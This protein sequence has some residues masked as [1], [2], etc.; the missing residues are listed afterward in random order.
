MARWRRFAVSDAT[1]TRHDMFKPAS[2]TM[3]AMHDGCDSF[4]ADMLQSGKS[5]IA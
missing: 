1:L 2:R 3:P 5:L 4:A